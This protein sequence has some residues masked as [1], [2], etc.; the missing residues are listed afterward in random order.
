V[1]FTK[2]LQASASFNGGKQIIQHFYFKCPYLIREHKLL[3]IS[4][5]SY[6]NS[7][8]LVMM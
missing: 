8:G 7:H 3:K 4:C 5:M 2:F 1:W 6:Y